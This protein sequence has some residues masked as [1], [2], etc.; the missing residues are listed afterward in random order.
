M[1]VEREAL[2]KGFSPIGKT[3]KVLKILDFLPLK[4]VL[5]SFNATFDL[6]LIHIE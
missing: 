5:D 2:H 4:H 6:P 1:G 3:L